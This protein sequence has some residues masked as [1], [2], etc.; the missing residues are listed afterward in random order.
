MGL[1]GGI[2]R[3]LGVPGI[4]TVI[5]TSTCSALIGDLV[6]RALAGQRPLLTSLAARQGATARMALKVP[7]RLTSIWSCQSV[8][9]ISRI[10]LKAWMPALAKRMSILPKVSAAPSDRLAQ[11]R[12]VA[13]VELAS[14]PSTA[15]VFYEPP[16][17]IQFRARGGLHL[18]RVADR[19]RDVDPDD[20][21]ALAR[22][23][24]GRGP[25]DTA[26]GFRHDGNLTF[27][28]LR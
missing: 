26:C 8:S 3:A 11:C 13:L 16:R 27:Q 23:S 22:K 10:G 17:L 1:Q 20:R 2:G 18:Q 19:S 15:R 21:R 9:S 25:T 7:L 5:F 28:S 6:E 14:V 12:Q 4:M 24:D